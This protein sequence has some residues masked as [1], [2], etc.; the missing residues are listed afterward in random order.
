MFPIPNT[1]PPP[2]YKSAKVERVPSLAE[3]LAKALTDRVMSNWE[4]G[5]LPAN[6]RISVHYRIKKDG[7]FA[8][9]KLVNSSGIPQ[10]DFACLEAVNESSGFKVFP[11]EIPEARFEEVESSFLLSQRRNNFD[12]AKTFFQAHPEAKK[13]GVVWHLIPL[14]ALNCVPNLNPNLIHCQDNLR[15]IKTEYINSKE[16]QEARQEW[17]TFLRTEKNLSFRKL[18]D[19]AKSIE[20][21]Y[22]VM[23]ARSDEKSRSPH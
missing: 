17:V 15:L 2:G 6:K 11:R 18:K 19:K 8:D 23:F 12:C 14:D 4:P 13:E 5:G 10:A 20:Q 9:I 16:M 7:R 22:A 1:T 21:K 3:R